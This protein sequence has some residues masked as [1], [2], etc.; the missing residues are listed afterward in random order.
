LVYTTDRTREWVL[1]ASQSN[2]RS[3]RSSIDQHRLFRVTASNHHSHRLTELS[4]QNSTELTVG[5]GCPASNSWRI[6]ARSLT[7]G[8]ADWL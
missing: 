2:V 1:A 5:H 7:S 6:S 8:S 4:Q 3:S